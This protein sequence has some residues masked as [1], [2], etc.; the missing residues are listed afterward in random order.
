MTSNK[1]CY[2]FWKEGHAGYVKKFSGYYYSDV[3]MPKEEF[4]CIESLSIQVSIDT[5]MEFIKAH[6]GQLHQEAI[7]DKEWVNKLYNKGYVGIVDNVIEVSAN[8]KND[9]LYFYVASWPNLN[10]Y[11]AREQV[12]RLIKKVLSGKGQKYVTFNKT[13]LDTSFV[14]Y[15]IVKEKAYD[16]KIN[17]YRSHLMKEWIDNKRI[18]IL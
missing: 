3:K 15:F 1:A 6:R 18:N 12:I 13:K 16:N 4:Y 5:I 9:Y 17:E 7:Y 14:N 2:I 11:L 8:S 10:G